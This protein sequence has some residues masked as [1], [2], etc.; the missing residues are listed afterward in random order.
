M[1]IKKEH[2]DLLKELGLKEEDFEH[3]NGKLVRYEYDDQKG[4]RL[5]DPYY[6]TSYNEYIDADGWSSW[7]TEKDTFM[8]DILKGAKRE[9]K[10]RERKSVK[11]ADEEI[12]RS[13]RKKFGKKITPKSEK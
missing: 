12:A 2:K 4:V 6:T 3:L 7:S 13:L 8:S 11:P 10:Q 9:A 1:K 5:Y